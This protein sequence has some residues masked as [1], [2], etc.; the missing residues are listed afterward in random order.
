M[1]GQ[2]SGKDGESVRVLGRFYRAGRD[3]PAEEK[4]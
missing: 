4:L 3:V 2:S 1:R